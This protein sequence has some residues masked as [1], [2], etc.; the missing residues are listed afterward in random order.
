M[1]IVVVKVTVMLSDIEDYG[2]MNDVYG[3]CKVLHTQFVELSCQLFLIQRFQPKGA[4][5]ISIHG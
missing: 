4:S 1:K 2:A 3:L 5:A